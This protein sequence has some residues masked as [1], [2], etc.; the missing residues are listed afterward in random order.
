[1]LTAFRKATSSTM[2]TEGSALKSLEAIT[3]GG[4]RGSGVRSVRI[5]NRGS[6]S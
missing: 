2:T 1:M 3:T 6:F 4:F 5:L